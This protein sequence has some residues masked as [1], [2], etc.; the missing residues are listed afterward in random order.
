M[1]FLFGKK[2]TDSH[3]IYNFL[4]IK[5]SIKK[6]TNIPSFAD[7]KTELFELYLTLNAKEN[8]SYKA[9]NDF[10][11]S[12]MFHEKRNPIIKQAFSQLNFLEYN[13]YNLN[14][15]DNYFIWSTYPKTKRIE[16]VQKA[17]YYNKPI[18]TLETGFIY[19]FDVP[20]SIDK[21][22][23]E[24]FQAHFSFVMDNVVPHYD[25]RYQS[26]LEKM[27]NDKNLIITDE[28]KKRA[29]DCIEKMVNN[30]ITKYNHQ[31]IFEPNIGRKGVKKVLVID[32]RYGDMSIIKGRASNE[33]FTKMLDCAIKENPD[34]DIIVKTHPDSK[35]DIYTGYYVKSSKFWVNY[36]E[37]SS[38]YQGKTIEI[39]VNS[40]GKRL[41]CI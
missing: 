18:W 1:S 2:I 7:I 27:L 11:G 40:H 10:S 4:G 5:I 14:I 32:Q 26:N 21:N 28:Q 34:S 17:Y 36:R 41:F 33:T 39:H 23:D 12:A 20:I 24:K 35:T 15:A 25:A 16:D 37:I 19:S 3:I 6:Q 31:P 9:I 13:S 30:H 8:R 38:E 22:I 29:R